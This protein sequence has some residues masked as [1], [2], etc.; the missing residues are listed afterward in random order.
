[1]KWFLLMTICLA[2]ALAAIAQD[3]RDSLRQPVPDYAGAGHAPRVVTRMADSSVVQP[4]YL[5]SISVSAVRDFVHRFKQATNTRWNIID[6]GYVAKFD[7]PAMEFQVGY[8]KRGEWTYTIR[9]YHEKQM[10]RDVRGMVKSIYYDFSIVQVK[11]V[12]QFNF[13]G[14]VYVVYLEDDS[15][16]K[17]IRV[18]NGEMEEMK[19]L[20]KRPVKK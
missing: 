3:A 19:M 18:Y 16:W 2:P 6:G 10:A 9:T 15:C 12:E 14:I 4:G 1:M 17:T 20:Y 7:L 13:E 5:N 8:D 11:E